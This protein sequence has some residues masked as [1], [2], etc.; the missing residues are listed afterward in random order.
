MIYECISVLINLLARKVYYIDNINCQRIFCIA[1]QGWQK[2][3]GDGPAKLS[4]IPRI[5][6]TQ[7]TRGSEGMPPPGN[8]WKLDAQICYFWHIFTITMKDIMYITLKHKVSV[9]KMTW[10]KIFFFFTIND[11]AKTGQTGP[12][13]PA[14]HNMFKLKPIC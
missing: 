5:M 13:P 7:A 3:P 11:L 8:F 9:Y 14:L 1:L 10:K 4:T 6:G 2:Q 12:L